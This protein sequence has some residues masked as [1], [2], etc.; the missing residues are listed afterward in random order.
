MEDFSCDA[1][2]AEEQKPKLIVMQHRRAAQ[3]TRQESEQPEPLF[4]GLVLAG[5]VMILSLALIHWLEL[6]P[7]P[8]G[9]F[10]AD[11]CRFVALIA[12]VAVAFLLPFWL[13]FRR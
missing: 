3:T 13:L 12:G 9:R 5:L 2:A 8:P 7:A 1:D 10:G 11:F 6:E 4:G